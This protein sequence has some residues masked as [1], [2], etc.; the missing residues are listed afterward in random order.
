MKLQRCMIH[1]NEILEQIGN[2]HGIPLRELGELVLPAKESLAD[3]V[4]IEEIR[5]EDERSDR[6]PSAV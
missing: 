5:T 3:V 1:D 2:L 6:A 4:S